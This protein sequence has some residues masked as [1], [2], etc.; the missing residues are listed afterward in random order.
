MQIERGFAWHYKAYE[1]DQSSVDRKRMLM[2]KMQPEP[3]GWACGPIRRLCRLGSSGDRRSKPI[4]YAELVQ[5]TGVRFL[6]V[7]VK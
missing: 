6:P 4:S 2:L 5:R 1:R 7:V 3:L